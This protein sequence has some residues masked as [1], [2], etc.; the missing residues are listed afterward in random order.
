M[1]LETLWINVSYVGT[2]K[3]FE[4]LASHLINRDRDHGSGIVDMINKQQRI[5]CCQLKSKMAQILRLINVIVSLFL[6]FSIE[7]HVGL[8]LDSF[9]KGFCF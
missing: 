7:I 9:L 2:Y 1:S 3:R 6:V 4:K 8:T 5:S